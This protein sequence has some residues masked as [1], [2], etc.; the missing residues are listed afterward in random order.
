MDC[1]LLYD[2]LEYMKDPEEREM[3]FQ[4]IQNFEK[5]IKKHELRKQLIHNDFNQ[6]NIIVS[7]NELVGI[8]DFGDVTFSNLV[9]ELAIAMY[10]IGFDEE[11]FVYW[12]S[13]VLE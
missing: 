13:L 3:A 11:D 4:M 5:G 1:H 12:S 8:I 10:S 7:N 2:K 6:Y 9:S